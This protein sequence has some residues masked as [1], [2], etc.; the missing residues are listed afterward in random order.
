MTDK[1]N[2]ITRKVP[3]QRNNNNNNSKNKKTQK[4]QTNNRKSRTSTT[5]WQKLQQKFLYDL[6]LKTLVII[7]IFIQIPQR[8]H[9]GERM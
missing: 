8:V 7:S 6:L 5:A 3:G 9:K 1:I 4:A 2:N